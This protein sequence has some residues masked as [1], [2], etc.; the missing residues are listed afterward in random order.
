MTYLLDFD[1]VIIIDPG[2]WPWMFLSHTLFNLKYILY[3]FKRS[4]IFCSTF[5]SS[6]V[7][8]HW[9]L[10]SIWWIFYWILVVVE[11]VVVDSRLIW[12]CKMLSF[13]H[14][15]VTILLLFHL[16][17]VFLPALDVNHTWFTL[18]LRY[19][20][21][22]RKKEISRIMNLSGSNSYRNGLLFA[23]FNQD[24]G[25]W[26]GGCFCLCVLS[27][28]KVRK[29]IIIIKYIL[30]ENKYLI[31]RKF[32]GTIINSHGKKS[33]QIK[34]HHF[35]VRENFHITFCGSAKMI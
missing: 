28:T 16:S 33:G 7:C 32:C 10:F 15:C 20:C 12:I 19:F 25:M 34:P 35:H 27:K 18:D 13:D 17:S 29:I 22:Y 1:I 24:Q 2:Y 31:T 3:C 23:G 4:S 11:L 6:D 30:L 8:L 21:C 14:C 9:I 26:A 5:F